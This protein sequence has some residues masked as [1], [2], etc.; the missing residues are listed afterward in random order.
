MRGIFFFTLFILSAALQA[1]SADQLYLSGR[2][3]FTDERW[4]VASSL[5]SRLLR[6]YPEDYRS[7]SS[8]YMSA[9]AHYNAGEH[10]RALSILQSFALHYPKSAWNQR[11]AYWEGMVYFDLGKW[12]A[13]SEAFGRQLNISSQDAY[14]VNSLFHIAACKENLAQ[15]DQAVEIY[16]RIINETE[17][18]ETHARAVFR[19]GQIRLQQDRAEEALAEFYRLASDYAQSELSFE[20]EFWIAESYRIM[21]RPNDA[22]SAYQNY[23]LKVFESSLRPRAL[24]AAA[25]LASMMGKSDEALA[26]LDL[27]EQ[28]LDTEPDKDEPTVRRIRAMS[29]L[30][31]GDLDKA[32]VLLSDL[33]NTPLNAQDEQLIAFN[34]AQSWIGTSSSVKSI[35]LLLKAS[36]GPDEKMSADALYFAGTIALLHKDVSGAGYLDRFARDHLADERREES[37]KIA[38]KAWQEFGER[39]KAIDDLSLL[40]SDFPDSAERGAYHYL[41]GELQLESGNSTEALSDFAAILRLSGNAVLAA[42]ARSRMGFIYA[43][44]G[45]H[46]RAAEYYVDAVEHGAGRD[47]LYSAGVSFFNGRD[48]PQAAETFSKLVS[49]D[50]SLPWVAESAYHLGEIR[51]QQGDYAASRL[52][53]QIASESG[54]DPWVFKALYG[55]AWSWY[56]E[57]QWSEAEQAF[58]DAAG[59][60]IDPQDKARSIY[61]IGLSQASAE[62]WDEAL[63]TYDTALAAGGGSW[64]EEAL[65][66][67]AW[68]LYRLNKPEDAFLMGS[69]LLDEFPRSRL[70]ADIPFRMAEDFFDSTKFKDA[71]FWY[72]RTVDAFPE[73]E[74][75]G[76]AILRA[77]LAAGESGN[78]RD[79]AQRYSSWLETHPDNTAA[80]TAMRA[81]AQVLLK[82]GNPQLTDETFKRI[83][84]IRSSVAFRAPLILAWARINGLPE[85]SIP[86]LEEIAEDPNIPAADKLE[87]LLLRAR[88]YRRNGKPLRARQIFEIL[89][90][91]VP[92]LLGA[93]AQLGLARTFADEGKIDRAL[94]AYDELA[95]LYPEQEEL[96]SQALREAENL[97]E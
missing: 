29:Y 6:E 53:Y 48:M 9:L 61:R 35:P 24:L 81:L 37:L 54:K 19:T 49:G 25:R 51:Y 2:E 67:K 27:R 91:D 63:Q 5:F 97:K 15:F 32:R 88:L 82:S 1:Q 30:R 70:A 62:R 41:R 11:I 77:A 64:R 50:P 72:D 3:A 57:S 4:E 56:R 71:V 75:A 90:R 60:A 33:L 95:Y 85:A 26:Y 78:Y 12:N 84:K 20:I 47:A 39:Q 7:D 59:A 34:L 38:L 58:R 14:R 18:Y 43:D 93:Q 46:I 44:R 73:S 83:E 76:R 13:A 55:T 22:F 16:S 31:M 21:G 23:L 94:Q 52:A 45:E 36:R 42:E 92:G 80:A 8:A 89:V 40:I 68:A 96:I 79:A 17:D 10:Q 86:L 66:Q 65:Y 74:Q 69:R 87:A 28:E